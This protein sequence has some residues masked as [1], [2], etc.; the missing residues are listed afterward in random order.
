MTYIGAWIWSFENG[1]LNDHGAGEQKVNTKLWTMISCVWTDKEMSTRGNTFF[2][3]VVGIIQ[4]QFVICFIFTSCRLKDNLIC[5]EIIFPS[6][7]YYLCAWKDMCLC[8]FNVHCKT[9]NHSLFSEPVFPNTSVRCSFLL[10]NTLKSP[11]T[12]D[13]QLTNLTRDLHV[14]LVHGY[15]NIYLE[16][17]LVSSRV[18]CSKEQELQN[19]CR[20]SHF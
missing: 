18:N 17:I 13:L 4:C 1:F 7:P 2:F 3:F 20:L 9:G 12:A 6:Y 14:M 8:Y 10:L 19:I 5:T 11:V 16:Y 15:L